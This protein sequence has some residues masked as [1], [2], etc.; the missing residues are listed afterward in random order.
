MKFGLISLA[1]VHAPG[2][3]EQIV[4]SGNELVGVWDDNEDRLRSFLKRFKTKVY[5]S[6]DDLLSTPE[7]EA[8]V[9]TSPTSDHLEH[10]K[11]ALEHGKHILCEKPLSTNVEEGKK[12][13]ELVNASSSKFMM[14]FPS[15]LDPLHLSVKKAINSGIIGDILEVKVR[16]S[17]SG[18]I[19][20][21]FS[22]KSW[23]VDPIKAGGGG[24]MDLGVHG[25][26]FM[27]W[28]LEAEAVEVNGLTF[29]LTGRYEIDDHGIAV[30][31]FSNGVIGVL[32]AGW[33]QSHGYNP[34]EVYGTQGSVLK[35]GSESLK[36]YS[37]KLGGWF[38]PDVPGKR[39]TVIERFVSY[40]EG[41][42]TPLATAEDG[43]KAT[44]IIQATYISS[45]LDGRKVSIPL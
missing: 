3:A 22:D 17:H 39:E 13:L 44:E 34:L 38:T 25:A 31:R 21:W 2:Y 19:D 4:K 6:L 40:V 20:G 11:K 1:H 41:R 14:S 24:F 36:I 33:A 35:L 32:E 9:I 8:V 16:V 10:I 42:K 28:L 12:I 30:I 37:R 27:R 29:N 43:Y 45:K 23:F 15:R 18:A 5:D 26:D 7:I